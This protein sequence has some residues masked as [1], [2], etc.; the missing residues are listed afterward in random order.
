MAND[1]DMELE[2]TQKKELTE[3]LGHIQSSLHI[4][5]R[6]CHRC[7]EKT[8]GLTCMG[9][10]Y[11]WNDGLQGDLQRAIVNIWEANSELVEDFF[12]FPPLKDKWDKEEFEKMVMNWQF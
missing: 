12:K 7:L 5:Q 9:C 8:N 2:N 11:N 10:C 4:L 6:K 3:I 1:T